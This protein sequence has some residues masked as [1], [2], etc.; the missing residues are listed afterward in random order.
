MA[1]T[2]I[3][4]IKQE[5]VNFI[6]SSDII[7]ISTRGVTTEQD[8]GTFTADVSH[9]LAVS[10]T[11]VKNIRQIDVG[12]NILLWGKDYQLNY[13]TGV[14]TFTVA[15]TGAYTIDYD[16]GS[17]D[18]IYPDFPQ[19]H[20]KIKDFPR[21]AVD[22]ISGTTEE[23]ELGA[24]SNYSD[25][26]VQVNAYD[27]DQNDVENMIDLL[28]SSFIDNKKNFYYSPFITPVGTG[29]IVVTPVGQ[30]KIVQRNQDLH[31]R[32]VFETI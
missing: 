30:D 27:K 21:I 20:L 23:V 2:A 22:I 17:T 24:G 8:T 32:F 12:G 29:P 19:P 25:Y 16:V 3:F 5:I 9:T 31:V 18:R 28:R 26:I 6:R 14:I 11:L 7:P 13:N 15:Q 4:N 1:K 10:P